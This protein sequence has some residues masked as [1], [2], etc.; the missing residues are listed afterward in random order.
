MFAS[1]S[2][3]VELPITESSSPVTNQR[4]HTHFTS[5]KWL[6]MLF[7]GHIMRRT[8]HMRRLYARFVIKIDVI[9]QTETCTI[10]QVPLVENNTC[11][12]N[13]SIVIWQC[14]ENFL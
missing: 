8:T 6:F 11:N 2:T 10:R 3:Q 1:F 5:L 4:H 12:N 14:I 13:G 7:W 9:Y